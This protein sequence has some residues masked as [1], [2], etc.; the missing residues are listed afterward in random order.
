MLPVF[1]R[2]VFF[3][4]IRF[5][6]YDTAGL[7]AQ[8]REV[9]KHLLA[10]ADGFVI[11][12][13]VEDKQSYILADAIRKEIKNSTEKK[14]QVT[15][16]RCLC[17]NLYLDAGQVVLVLGTKV[18]LAESRKV[19][20]AQAQVLVLCWSLKTSHSS[21]DLSDVG[22]Q[23][24]SKTC[25]SVRP[26]P[27]LLVRAVHVPGKQAEP[28]AEQI[29]SCADHLDDQEAR[30]RAPQARARLTGGQRWLGL[31]LLIS[32]SCQQA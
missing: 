30:Q 21:H 12:Y 17:Y 16:T 8:Q 32:A 14:D 24:E 20:S 11:V 28:A 18:D 22:S 9:P 1:G 27:A 3:L 26:R 4:F 25:R 23:R 31:L 13:S 7:D 2:N 10:A 15:L 19:D 29:S 5:R 6:F